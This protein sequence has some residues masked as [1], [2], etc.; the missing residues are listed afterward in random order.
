MLRE[1]P[2]SWSVDDA[3]DLYQV[4]RWGKGFFSVHRNGYLIVHPDRHPRRAVDLKQLVD[5]L[6]LQGINP[7]LLVRF[8]GILEDRIRELHQVFAKAVEAHDYRGQYLA[9]YPI[10]VNQQRQVV[11]QIVEFGKQYGFG[12]EAGSKPELMAVLAHAH[13]ETPVICNGFKD[14]QFVEMVVLAQKMGRSVIPI[15]EQ[16]SELQLLQESARRMGVRP[17]FGFRVKLATAGSGRWQASGGCH[18]KFGLTMDEV[19]RAFDRLQREEM[20]DCLELLHFHLGSQVTNVFSIKTALTEISRVYVDL[21]KQ[22]AGLKV[23]NVGGGLA[24]DYDGSQTDAQSSAN[25]T[26]EEYAN[27]VVH[28]VRTVCDDAGVAHPDIISESGRA[29]A[30]YHSALIVEVVGQTGPGG[31]IHE[32]ETTVSAVKEKMPAERLAPLPLADLDQTHEELNP[33]NLHESFHD[34][35]QALET[36]IN[37]FS[38]GHITLVQRSRAENLFWSIC[39]KIQQL[40]LQLEEIP[41][42][43]RLLEAMLAPTYL[44]NFSLFQSIPDSWAIKQ[45]FPVMPIHRLHQPPTCPAVLGDMTCDSDG[46]ID[47]FISGGAS[48]ATLMLHPLG[49]E[50]YYLAGLLVGAYQEILGDLHNLFG[51]THAVHVDINEVGEVVLETVIPGDTVS[52]VLEYV[53]F[54]RENL[55]ARLEKSVDSAVRQGRLNQAEAK[56]FLEYYDQG[57]DGYTYLESPRA[58]D[59]PG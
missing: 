48:A 55:L 26:L 31:M 58:A 33:D 51:D 49:N 59:L 46:R 12:L 11:E 45:L 3:R 6:K 42:D 37:M 2:T 10:K 14:F 7:P 19:L 52:E 32:L 56:R 35:Q 29:I 54:D 17:R 25:Y 50:P 5:R 4:D 24:V 47:R 28:Y 34:A 39:R 40:A 38:T 23:I 21:V 18:S 16:F 9:V 20:A 22:G 8:N 30:A 15:V 36:A 44:C 1:T 41:K 13:E 43:L 57:L 53:C 27:D